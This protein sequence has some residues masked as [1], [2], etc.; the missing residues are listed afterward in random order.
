MKHFQLKLAGLVGGSVEQLGS[1]HR[2][3]FKCCQLGTKMA[4]HGYMQCRWSSRLV[5]NAHRIDSQWRTKS[6]VTAARPSQ[7]LISLRRLNKCKSFKYT[8]NRCCQIEKIN[9]QIYIKNLLSEWREINE[10]LQ[11]K[12]TEDMRFNKELQRHL[13]D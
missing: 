2:G 9:N 5:R 7:S 12:I 11:N 10:K 4:K 3:K 8:F 6:P 1:V 13:S